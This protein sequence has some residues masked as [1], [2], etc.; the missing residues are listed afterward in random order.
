[1]AINI[2]ELTALMALNKNNL[3]QMERDFLAVAGMTMEEY[4][5]SEVAKCVRWLESL[6]P[7]SV[8]SSAE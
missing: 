1:M 7:P 3:T 6:S 8:D 4:A 2:F 5:K